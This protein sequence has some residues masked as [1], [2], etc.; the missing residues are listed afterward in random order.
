M[1]L[2]FQTKSRKTEYSKAI[3]ITS[4][5]SNARQIVIHIHFYDIYDGIVLFRFSNSTYF[6]VTKA[7]TLANQISAMLHVTQF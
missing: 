3:L 1:N 4:R 7:C 6:K 5:Y 2:L